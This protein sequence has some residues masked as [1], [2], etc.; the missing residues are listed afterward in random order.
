SILLK[1]LTDE[2]KTQYG[3]I[4]NKDH[5]RRLG[6]LRGKAVDYLVRQVV[7]AFIKN[8][9]SIMA[10][11]FSEEIIT[12]CEKDAIC[13]VKSAKRLAKERVFFHP[14][15][16]QIEI[17]AYAIIDVLLKAC[18]DAYIDVKDERPSFRSRRVFDLLGVNA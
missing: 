10:G 7:L 14:S 9:E 3:T 2:E 8:E 17:G 15:K 12:K 5:P 11:E 1:G 6:Y 18:C 4:P 13:I 16:I